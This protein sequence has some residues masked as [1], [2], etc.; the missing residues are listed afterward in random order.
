VAYLLKKDGKLKEAVELLDESIAAS[1]RTVGFYVFKA[2]LCEELKELPLAIQALERATGLFPDDEKVSYYL[3]SLY[4]R[5][6]DVDHGLAEMERIL[7]V[8]PNN[9]DALNYIGY[10]WTLRGVRLTDAGTYIRKA[11]SLRPD[12]AY[13][14]DSWGWHLF[15]TGKVA[16][17]MIELEIAQRQKPQEVTILDHL[18]EVY[19]KS[20]LMESAYRTLVNAVKYAPDSESRE[21]FE[22]RLEALKTQ[23][24]ART[25]ARSQARVPAANP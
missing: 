19:L 16:E 8:N 5:V 20:S 2:N 22:A 3:G 13:I 17:A 15:L 18:A 10:T 9:V 7:K 6:G 11:L 12:N 4:D 23:L 1:G 14:R 24:A 25:G 21:R